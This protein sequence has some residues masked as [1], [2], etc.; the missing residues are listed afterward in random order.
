MINKR[1]L[2]TRVLL[3]FIRDIEAR[4][5]GQI[6]VVDIGGGL[7]TSYTQREEPEGFTY[8]KYRDLLDKE[9]D[10][11]INNYCHPYILLP[12]GSRAFYWQVPGGHRVWEIDVSQNGDKSDQVLIV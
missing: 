12:L 10:K 7:S 3:D 2:G 11:I 1:C 6:K 8:Q 5:P 9:A 4:C